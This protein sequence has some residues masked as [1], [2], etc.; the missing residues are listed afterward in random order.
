MSDQRAVVVIGGGITGLA[1]AH[2]LSRGGVRTI[3][4]EA[5]ERLGGKLTTIEVGGVRVESGAD[6]FL[7]RTGSVTEFC[8][9]LGIDGELIEPRLFGGLVCVN[10][11]LVPLPKGTILGVPASPRVLFGAGPLSLKGKLRGLADLVF[12]GPLKGPDISVG[13]YIRKRFGNEVLERMVDPLLAGT[14]AGDP[15]EMSLAAAL[16]AIDTVARSH[17][18]L[19]RGLAAPEGPPRF[20][21]HTGGMSALVETIAERVT[22]EIHLAHEVNKVRTREAGGY[23]VET[24]TRSFDADGVIVC[25]PSEP[26]SRM[27]EDLSPIAA[28]TL[29]SVRHSSVASVVLVYDE[30]PRLPPHSSGLLIPTRERRSLSAA[31]W[32][33]LKWP[34]TTPTGS[35]A[36]RC[37]A[38]RGD[39]GSLEN[40]ADDELATTLERELFE[41]IGPLGA[42]RER[43]VTRWSNGLPIYT[44]GHLERVRAIETAL[45]PLPGLA[46]VGADLRGSG[47]PDCIDQGAAA[48]RSILSD[49][50]VP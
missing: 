4:L 3:L 18:S 33:S 10:G 30:P 7:D 36:I 21:T 6:S 31:T 19:M 2:A 20:L 23:V 5:S 1:A 37:F 14:R 8:R 45:K 50:K 42:A 35:F 48:A 17:A 22:A 13:A 28:R 29:G 24:Q 49:L 46:V 25:A 12:P 40:M 16:P 11:D 27:L 9:E 41:L 15:D 44:V 38:G 43:H 39:D 47:I 34:D 32:W 26:A